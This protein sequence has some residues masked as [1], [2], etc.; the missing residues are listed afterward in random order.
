VSDHPYGDDFAQYYDLL[1]SDKDYAGEVDLIDRILREESKTPAKTLLDAGC[2]TAGHAVQ[3]AKRG[4]RVVGVDRMGG[5]LRIA[6]EKATR[7]G[8]TVDFRQADLR[9]LDLGMTCD[10]AVAMF[11]V[12]SFQIE[13][14]DLQAALKSVRRH[15]P[16]GG[17]FIFDVWHGAAV[18]S[19]GLQN[20]LKTV[21]RD[22][23]RLMRFATPQMDPI[24]QTTTTLHHMIVTAGDKTVREVRESQ[25]VRFL[26]AMEMTLHLQAAGFDLVR[27]FD[28]PRYDQ[29]PTE[30]SWN[31][32]V[33]ARARA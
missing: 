2:G 18:L 24:R 9:S 32:G 11:A 22:G 3:L 19:E 30:R 16:A 29:L 23:V 5:M 25:T 31:L 27:T 21:E 17:L 33:V 15:L 13:N 7:A 14:E 8:V 1:Y 6:R 20:R 10:A 12:L 26:F 4:Y 28:F